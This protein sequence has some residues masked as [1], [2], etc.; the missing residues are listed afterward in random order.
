MK[1]RITELDGLRALAVLLVFLNHY[2]P[3]ESMP[4]LAPLRRVGWTGV[5]IFFVLSGFLITGILLDTRF[6]KT[7]YYK[8]FYI[9]RSLRIFPLYYGLLTAVLLVMSVSR[10]GSELRE[11]IARWGHPAWLYTYL[12]N[13]KIAVSNISPSS[14]FVPM[15]SLHVEEQFYLV[16][17]FLVR[18]LPLTQ[19]KRVLIGAVIAA[20]LIRLGLLWL[21]PA[22]PLLQYMLLP[23]RMDALALGALAAIGSPARER[24][25][26]QSKALS[27]VVICGLLF[28]AYQ[29]FT[30]SGAAFNTPFERTIGYSLFDFAFAG[31]LLLILMFR[32]GPATAWLNWRILQY[33][34]LISYGL[35][36]FQAPAASLVDK[37]VR[38]SGYVL[39]PDTALRA[40]CIAATCTGL[41]TIS[42]YLWESPWLRLKTRFGR[43]HEPYGGSAESAD[44]AWNTRE[45]HIPQMA[46]RFAAGD[47]SSARI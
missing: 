14:Y 39:G 32:G 23:C 19:L 9:R 35:Y 34:G 17:P 7:G 11:M 8:T 30:W 42:W 28:V 40:F 20:P 46:A 31:C 1:K 25:S 13:V 3:V 22:R 24:R 37:L 21:F 47:D 6:H 18:R 36:L 45:H 33:V 12:A 4:W 27:T 15:W 41:A 5:D 16:F 43:A 10:N 26:P 29:S 44:F 38:T 2:A